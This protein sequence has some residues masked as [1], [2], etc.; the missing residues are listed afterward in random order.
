MHRISEAVA[1]PDLALC[2]DAILNSL[3]FFQLMLNRAA[4]LFVQ[5]RTCTQ[6]SRFLFQNDTSFTFRTFCPP[7]LRE[8]R[9]VVML[10]EESRRVREER[11]NNETKTGKLRRN[12]KELELCPDTKKLLLKHSF[13]GNRSCIDFLNKKASNVPGS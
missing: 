4:P 6:L 8:L 2:F 1:S 5:L 7:P 3:L 12:Q 11:P 9:L 10:F 13:H